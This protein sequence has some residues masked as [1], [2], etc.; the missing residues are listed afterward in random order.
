MRKL[1]TRKFFRDVSSG[2][3]RIQPRPAI[4]TR[5][6]ARPRGRPSLVRQAL[7][8]CVLCFSLRGRAGF[9]GICWC[10]HPPGSMIIFHPLAACPARHGLPRHGGELRFVFWGVLGPRCFAC[11]VPIWGLVFG[12]GVPQRPCLEPAK[13]AVVSGDTTCKLKLDLCSDA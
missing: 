6:E 9:W 4:Q 13:A 8:F 12:Q 5:P 11:L 10:F 3:P 1:K 2:R 7:L